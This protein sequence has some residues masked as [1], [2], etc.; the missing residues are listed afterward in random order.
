MWSQ[1]F[2]DTKRSRP[3]YKQQQVK[4]LRSFPPTFFPERKPMFSLSK[5]L[6]E[7][8][9]ET[10]IP[11]SL[12]PLFMLMVHKHILFCGIYFKTYWYRNFPI[13]CRLDT[14][15]VMMTLQYDSI[16]IVFWLM[17]VLTH[18]LVGWNDEG[19]GGRDK[20]ARERGDD[21]ALRCACSMSE[22]SEG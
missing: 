16:I 10:N 18:E 14:V 5:A 13:L 19:V 22:R 21:L 4:N 7:G 8:E 12:L 1:G 3:R 9:K 15:A 6:F 17:I 2:R 20:E 11:A